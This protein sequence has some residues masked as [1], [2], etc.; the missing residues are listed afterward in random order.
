MRRCTR[1]CRRVCRHHHAHRA[2]P[3]GAWCALEPRKHVS[4]PLA[5]STSS[6]T[7]TSSSTCSTGRGQ[8]RELASGASTSATSTTCTSPIHSRNL[9]RAR[10]VGVWL[11][12][13]WNE[14]T[15]YRTGQVR[16][17]RRGVRGADAVWPPPARLRLPQPNPTQP[18]ADAVWRRR[19]DWF[20]R[21]AEWFGTERQG[22]ARGRM[23]GKRE[24]AGMQ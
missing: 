20:S 18:S 24:C 6:I 4:W 14:A 3:G 12:N 10:M 11:L 23:A 7:R 15:R 17:L 8:P 19:L 16:Q 21:H 2:L 1:S 13:A 5:A 9:P 22:G